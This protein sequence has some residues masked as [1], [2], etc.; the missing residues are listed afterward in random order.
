[1]PRIILQYPFMR[2][3]A[4]SVFDLEEN[5]NRSD[6]ESDDRFYDRLPPKRNYF[7]PDSGKGFA[8]DL[9]ISNTVLCPPS[10]FDGVDLTTGP[11]RITSATT[12]SNKNLEVPFENQ[13]NID[14]VQLL[15]IVNQEK[16]GIRIELPTQSP[17]PQRLQI[18]ER[19]ANKI[20]KD[21][22]VNDYLLSL[23]CMELSTGFYEIRILCKGDITHSMTCIK[24]FPLVVTMDLK[25]HHYTTMKTIY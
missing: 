3:Y 7:L 20:L 11:C 6:N 10:V 18:I 8:I 25:T 17:S 19:Q 9:P 15:D 13:L 16:Q 2:H 4:G 21:I 1:M 5:L 22:T 14:K 23:D 12:K 24:C